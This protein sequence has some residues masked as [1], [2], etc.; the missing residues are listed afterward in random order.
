[1][2]REALTN[3]ASRVTSRMNVR[4]DNVTKLFGESKVVD[5]FDL[6]VAEGEFVVLLG[7]SGCGKTTTLRMLAGLEDAT[8]GD[9]FI[10]E[11]R[12]NDIPTRYRDVAMVFQSYA[13]YP[14]MTI[15][16]NI[17]YP[18]V[19]RKTPA[20]EIASRVHRVAE[21]LEIGALLKR[22]PRELSGGERQRVALARAI[23]RE[24]RVYLMDEPLSNLDA[25]LRVQMRGELKRLQHDLGT[26]TIY[27]THDQAEAMT[28]AH[29]VAVM[30]AGKLQQFETPMN[31][32]NRPANRFV[33]EF[34]G[35]P[36][37]NFLDV[38]IDENRMLLKA[39]GTIVGLSDSNIAA[40][41]SARPVTLGLRPEHIRVSSEAVD[42]WLAADVYVTELM[43]NETF[44]FLRLG[45]EKI[46]A[47]APAEFRAEMES[48]VWV[49][50]DLQKALF[51][52]S[53]TGEA[54]SLAESALRT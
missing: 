7:P 3:H 28:L 4:F 54:I 34:V 30:R 40:G 38:T 6:A 48:R 53:A 22:K 12:V 1:M 43:G 46:I 17:A 2:I 26:T 14:H 33:A 10:G 37:M 20:A 25:K 16:A 27:V 52:D 45:G 29:R 13:L 32:Y 8:S 15:A 41:N 21:M 50:F 35:S 47:R 5:H 42:G 11:Q 23:V 49:Q 31:I 39:D 36:S 19:V 51:F 24:P 18:L 44:V 9:I